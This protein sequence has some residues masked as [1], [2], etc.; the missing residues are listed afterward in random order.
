MFLMPKPYTFI[1]LCLE[2]IKVLSVYNV[3]YTADSTVYSLRE[4]LK[5]FKVGIAIYQ[6]KALFKAYHR[7]A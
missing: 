2:I 4:C 6:S 1:T 7:L 5:R 3:L